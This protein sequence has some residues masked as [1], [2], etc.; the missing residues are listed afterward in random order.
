MSQGDHVWHTNG[1][2]SSADG[3]GRSA[4]VR[5]FLSPTV[6]RMNLQEAQS[7]LGHD[8]GSVKELVVERTSEG[9]WW[10]ASC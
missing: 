9:G 1:W 5:S 6:M 2:K 4:T 7:Q 3:K 10:S 8:K